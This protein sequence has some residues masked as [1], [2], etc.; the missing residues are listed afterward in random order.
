MSVSIPKFTNDQPPTTSRS[1]ETN[2]AEM[3]RNFFGVNP[4]KREVVRSKAQNRINDYLARRGK[5]AM[6]PEEQESRQRLG[7]VLLK[8][9]AGEDASNAIQDAI[10]HG[11]LTMPKFNKMMKRAGILPFVE[12]FKMLT[13]EQQ[14]DVFSRTTP[15][16]RGLLAQILQDKMNR[17]AAAKE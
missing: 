1:P 14:L 9:R 4:A 10:A 8:L 7:Q 16:E 12:K 3:A 11:D 2:V 15:R 5:T 13:L 6:T 17:A